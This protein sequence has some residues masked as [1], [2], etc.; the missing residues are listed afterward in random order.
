MGGGV[1][2]GGGE[3]VVEG[4]RPAFAQVGFGAAFFVC[5]ANEKWWA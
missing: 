2:W 4:V 5:G 1:P 3:M